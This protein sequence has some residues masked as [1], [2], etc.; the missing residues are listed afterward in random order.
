MELELEFYSCL[1]ETSVFNINGIKASHSDF[2]YRYDMDSGNSED[3]CGDMKFIG[4]P[5]TLNILKKYN[6]TEEEYGEIILKLQKGLSF[7]SC[8]WCY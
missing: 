2:G 7:G 1:C 6:I 5:S 8:G 4:N 3:G